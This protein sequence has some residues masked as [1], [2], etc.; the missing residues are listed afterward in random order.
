METE[1][2]L[3]EIFND[4]TYIILEMLWNDKPWTIMCLYNPC[5]YGYY[6]KAESILNNIKN[7]KNALNQELILGL[8][9]ACDGGHRSIVDL[10]IKVGKETNHKLDW[11]IGLW[12]ACESG[13]LEIID[14]MID[15]GARS[16]N[17]GLHRSCQGGSIE[18][19]RRMIKYGANEI[20][21]GLDKACTY[22]NRDIAE[23]MLSLGADSVD[24]GL[25]NAC[26]CCLG[27]YVE[28][29]RLLIENGADFELWK[30]IWYDD[31]NIKHREI[32]RLIEKT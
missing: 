3:H 15:H 30:K 21:I 24:F 4:A 22:G 20:D 27:N 32:V 18:A 1:K 2:L 6:E 12:C 25:H 9:G 26:C 16:I 31:N 14:L 23:Y 8:R 5:F 11:N 17:I 7:D 13:S 19:V 28:V 29:I 10:I